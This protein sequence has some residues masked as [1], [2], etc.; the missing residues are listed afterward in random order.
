MHNKSKSD[1]GNLFKSLCNSRIRAVGSAP[2]ADLTHQGTSRPAA[3]ASEATVIDQCQ[4]ARSSGVH[5]GHLRGSAGP[6][7]DSHGLHLLGCTGSQVC[8]WPAWFHCCSRCW[9]VTGGVPAWEGPALTPASIFQSEPWAHNEGCRSAHRNLPHH[10]VS[11]MRPG[12]YLLHAVRDLRPR[13]TQ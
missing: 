4:V 9:A 8:H 7:Q 5:R 13:G 1:A 6:M 3:R 12:L 11:P 10:R 2:H